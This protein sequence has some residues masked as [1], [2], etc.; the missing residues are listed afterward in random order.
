MKNFFCRN[1]SKWNRLFARSAE[2]NSPVEPSDDFTTCHWTPDEFDIPECRWEQS[3]LFAR[4]D[5]HLREFGLSLRQW[6]CKPAQ[7]TVWA[8]AVLQSQYHVHRELSSYTNPS[9]DRSRGTIFGHTVS[10]NARTLP[11]DVKKKCSL[12]SNYK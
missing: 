10:Q 4:R 3:E 2:A 6:Q 8:G 12:F 7:L 1:S 5:W 11:V 9:G